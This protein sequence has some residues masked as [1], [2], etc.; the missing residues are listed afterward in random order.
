MSPKSSSPDS[1]GVS[2]Q[3]DSQSE[4]V[5]S[6]EIDLDMALLDDWSVIDELSNVVSKRATTSNAI[7][8]N[9]EDSYALFQNEEGSLYRHETMTEL[10]ENESEQAS[11][12]DQQLQSTDFIEA[13]ERLTTGGSEYEH[14]HIDQSN[15]VGG[16]LMIEKI[17]LNSKE[18]IGDHEP[19]SDLFPEF[20]S[21]HDPG[22]ISP[23]EPN[24]NIPQANMSSINRFL[25]TPPLTVK[26]NFEQILFQRTESELESMMLASDQ[27]MKLQQEKTE[28]QAA[29][30]S[31]SKSTTSSNKSKS[32][33]KRRPKRVIDESRVCEPTEH[34]VLFGRGGFT[35]THPGNIK[36]REEALKLRDWYESATKEEKY[37]ISDLLVETIRG[38]GHRFLE[39][40]SDGLWHEVIGNGARKKASQALRERLKRKKNN[41]RKGL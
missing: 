20:P 17:H 19:P 34:D 4:A 37:T 15:E 36:F 28:S 24:M 35:N 30:S 5:L 12:D 14:V 10:V 16:E 7:F 29:P 9:L 11:T 38:D 41:L 26:T 22:S 33:S 31:Q 8:A 3:S 25:P 32:K 21:G 40:G 6:M 23:T 2:L 27:E 13:F 1:I 39:K 18:W